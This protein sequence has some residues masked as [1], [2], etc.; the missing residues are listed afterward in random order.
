MA[1]LSSR[2]LM[3]ND[4]MKTIK[5][6]MLRVW[7]DLKADSDGDLSSS[8]RPMSFCSDT[9]K[10]HCD[11]DKNYAM[12]DE[13]CFCYNDDEDLWKKHGWDMTFEDE[14]DEK[15]CLVLSNTDY[16]CKCE[17]DDDACSNC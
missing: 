17:G 12:L 6:H 2:Q 9:F 4:A 15:Y 13:M 16:Y 11:R 5:K 14:G 7:N 8:G 3:V 10:L 1:K